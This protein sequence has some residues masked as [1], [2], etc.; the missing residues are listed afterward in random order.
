MPQLGSASKKHMGEASH[1]P[2]KNPKGAGLSEDRLPN[3]LALI[4][5]TL[6]HSK[7]ED[8]KSESFSLSC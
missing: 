2:G 6:T 7:P 4:Q 3:R 8:W 1:T 5:N